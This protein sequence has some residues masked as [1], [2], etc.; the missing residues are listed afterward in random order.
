MFLFAIRAN[1]PL[2]RELPISEKDPSFDAA[3]I[4]CSSDEFTI[5]AWPLASMAT[6][7]GW[8]PK[9]RSTSRPYLS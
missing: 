6:P 4:S 5:W 3:C 9:L 8:T 1:V 7:A 2:L